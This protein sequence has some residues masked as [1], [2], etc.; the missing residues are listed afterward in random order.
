MKPSRRDVLLAGLALGSAA[1]LFVWSRRTPAE[2]MAQ[3]LFDLHLP[4][5][6]VLLSDADRPRLLSVDLLSHVQSVVPLQMVARFMAIDAVRGVLAYAQDDVLVLRDLTTHVERRMSLPHAVAGLL[7]AGASGDWWVWGEN[8]LLRLDA[9]GG[10]RR[11][12]DG[13]GKIYGVHAAALVPQ[14]VV[15]EAAAVWRVSMDD[16]EMRR[17]A[18]P[19]GWQVVSRSA[20]SADGGL[21]LFAV[22][23]AVLKEYF[24]V[25]WQEEGVWRR[26]PMS[27]PSV[28]PLVDHAARQLFFVAQDGQGV[29]IDGE[30]L[31]QFSRFATLPNAEYMALGWLDGRLLLAGDGVLFLHDAHSLARLHEFA[32]PGR[33]NDVFVTADSKQALL[34]VEG[35]STLF[36]L[37]MHDGRLHTLPLPDGWRP[38][39]VLM[40]A[41]YTL[42]H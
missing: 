28:R 24:V 39:R 41:G 38:T 1:G 23:D 10:L 30:D 3:A 15:L 5:R 17:E 14:I 21:L 27:S 26:Y 6:V 36:L 16:G 9:E 40:G 8:V 37:D 35:V 34:S 12:S 18:L 4:T 11:L 7:S 19:A 20:L 32:V 22:Y 25:V 13:F 2:K 33:V 31:Q 29:R 42:C